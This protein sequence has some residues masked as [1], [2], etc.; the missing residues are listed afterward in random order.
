MAAIVA[1]YLSEKLALLALI[2][3]AYLTVILFISVCVGYHYAIDGI[4]SIAAVFW[5][6]RIPKSGRMPSFAESGRNFAR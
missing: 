4:V 5:M 1:L 6:N 3:W 2:G